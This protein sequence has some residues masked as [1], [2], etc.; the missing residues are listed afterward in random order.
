MMGRASTE[1]QQAVDL[2]LHALKDD[3]AFSK[4]AMTAMLKSIVPSMSKREIETMLSVVQVNLFDLE[5]FHE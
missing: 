5:D 2:L 4:E 3:A 1:N